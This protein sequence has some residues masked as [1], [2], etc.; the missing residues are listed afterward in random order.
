MN[1]FIAPLF[2]N[3]FFDKLNFTEYLKL[4]SLYYKT[5]AYTITL[6]NGLTGF[7]YKDGLQ[8]IE[9]KLNG[10]TFIINSERFIYLI[11]NGLPIIRLPN[12]G[13][14]SKFINLY[15]PDFKRGEYQKSNQKYLT[16]YSLKNLV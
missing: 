3:V 10:I 16:F 7:T 15:K 14:M 9:Y 12:E 4:H 11:P 13:G 6:C 8:I 2:I 1:N 5:K